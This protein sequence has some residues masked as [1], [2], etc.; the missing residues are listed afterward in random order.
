MFY[1]IPTKEFQTYA[2]RLCR[3][4]DWKYWMFWYLRLPRFKL[5]Y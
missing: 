3:S 4:L 1:A 5:K 2:W